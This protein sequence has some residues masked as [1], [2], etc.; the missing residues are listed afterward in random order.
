MI[1]TPEIASGMP[2]VTS[3]RSCVRDGRGQRGRMRRA[4]IA[5]T[6]EPIALVAASAIAR[7]MMPP[8]L[9]KMITT[10]IAHSRLLSVSTS[11]GTRLLTRSWKTRPST[12]VPSKG[13]IRIRIS[14]P[15]SIGWLRCSSSTASSERMM[16]GPSSAQPQQHHRAHPFLLALGMGGGFAHDH[17]FHAEG[18]EVADQAEH[19]QQRHPLPVADGAEQAGHERGDDHP[20]REVQH[21][22]DHLHE[23]VAGGAL[24]GRVAG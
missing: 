7:A 19:V 12:L 10:A 3:G 6:I 17:L 23:D 5:C 16:T 15:I 1:R 11:I 20:E 22:C 13:I 18:R 21:A 2:T 9:E 14:P 4:A 24:S 8:P